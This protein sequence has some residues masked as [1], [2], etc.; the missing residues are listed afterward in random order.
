MLATNRTDQQSR[1]LDRSFALF[2]ERE[3][4]RDSFR[5]HMRCV[6]IERAKT[7]AL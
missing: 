3:L 2:E 5:R 7:T 1:G 6:L 4:A